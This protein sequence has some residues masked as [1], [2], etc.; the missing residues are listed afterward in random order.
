MKFTL[1]YTNMLARQLGY[2]GNLHEFWL[3][4]NFESKQDNVKP[5][6]DI[7]SK[8]TFFTTKNPRTN[9]TFNVTNLNARTAI[10]N[11]GERP[12]YYSQ[13]LKAAGK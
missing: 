12:N 1:D 10:E 11:L 8:S 6:T 2:K 5:R 4:M 13:L 9:I 3:G 7:K